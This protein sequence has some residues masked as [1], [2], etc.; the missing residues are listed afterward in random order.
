MDNNN[1]EKRT[2]HISIRDNIGYGFGNLGYGIVFQV[3]ASYLVFY[4]TAIHNIPGSLIGLAVSIGVIW[5]GLTD[6]IMGYISDKTSNK[7]YGRRHLYLLIGCMGIAVFNY[8]L[9]IINAE[10]TTSMKFFW[11]FTDLI[12]IKSFLTV[13]ATPYT[14]LGAELSHDYNQRTSIQ[15]VKTIF[16]L[17]GIGMATVMGMFAF[18]QPTPEYPVGQLNPIA[19]RNLGLT[20]SLIML[21]SGI[22]C[23]YATKKY[24][25]VLPKPQVSSA[26]KEWYKRLLFD[27]K[28]ALSNKDY[29]VVVYAYL[30]T[31]IASALVSTFGLHVFTYTFKLTNNTIA[32]IFGTQI[33]ICIVT[34]PIWIRISKVLDKKPAAI[35]GLLINIVGG[36]VFIAMVLLRSHIEGNFAYF[37]PYALITGFGTS[38]LFTLPL[39]MIADTIDIEELKHGIRTEG[40]YYGCLTLFYKLSQS[41]VIFLLGVMLDLIRFN[42]DLP[43]QPQSTELVLGLTISVGS[44]VAF[45]ICLF[46]YSRY[47]LNKEKVDSAQRELKLR[48][49]T[50]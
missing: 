44:I 38:G 32:F 43:I 31:N 48:R 23:F 11:I 29:R 39:S 50:L 45:S 40:I 49:G 35:L 22:V 8:L 27:F 42:P 9:W 7:R 19:Y 1:T 24:I 15:G 26:G 6:P 47:S 16:F 21:A 17:T 36:L 34:Q 37:L 12:L 10:L 30:F 14:A 4:G 46:Y 5:D 18:F 2:G 3:I 41:L 20:A 28:A 25:P 33:A 13:Y